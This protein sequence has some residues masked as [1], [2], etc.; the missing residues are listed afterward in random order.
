[1][2]AALIQEAMRLI[3]SNRE[4]RVELA[5]AYGIHTTSA[6]IFGHRGRQIEETVAPLEQ[7]SAAWCEARAEA[8]KVCGVQL[9]RFNM[10]EGTR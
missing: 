5:R 7:P 1:M 9:R 6:S 8:E 3:A 10:E 2:S 4:A